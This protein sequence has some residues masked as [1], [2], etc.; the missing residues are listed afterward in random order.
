MVKRTTSPSEPLSKLWRGW[1]K[2]GVRSA[3]R[4]AKTQKCRN[5]LPSRKHE[6]CRTNSRGARNT[7]TAE[8]TLERE[9][10]KLPNK[11]SSMKT[12]NCRTNSVDGTAVDERGLG[13]GGWDGCGAQG[14]RR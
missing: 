7:K 12:R 2:A 4:R 1:P 5:E 14:G 10:T 9:N 3:G 6:S 8:Q 13:I 11:L